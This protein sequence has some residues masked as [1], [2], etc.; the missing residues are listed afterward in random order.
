MLIINMSVKVASLCCI[1]KQQSS[2]T[3]VLMCTE[4]V[5]YHI[6]YR[7]Q[8]TSVKDSKHVAHVL[9]VYAAALECVLRI[10]AMDSASPSSFIFTSTK[11]PRTCAS[12]KLAR[13]ALSASSV[14]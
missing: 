2:T 11:P 10:G 12:V 6:S 14:L 9:C 5:L 8:R 4:G 1:A 7:D 3:V 13:K